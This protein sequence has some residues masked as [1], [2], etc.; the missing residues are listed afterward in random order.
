MAVNVPALLVAI[1]VGCAAIAVVA[2]PVSAFAR[3]YVSDLERAEART[4]GSSPGGTTAEP[5]TFRVQWLLT[6]TSQ[7]VLAA[8]LCGVTLMRGAAG[9]AWG[10][11][12]VALP[13][14]ALLGA[15]CGVD[16]VCHRLPNRILGPAAMWTGAATVTLVLLNVVTGTPLSEAGWAALRSVLC[17]V[18]A[19][20]IVGAM[21]LLPGS[22]MGL[23]DAKLCAVLGLWLGYFGGTYAAMGI[24]LGF[25]IGGIVAIA[26]MISR[27]AGRKTL[28]AFGPYLSRG[29][30]LCGGRAGGAP[31]GPWPPPAARRESR[32]DSVTDRGV[33]RKG[34]SP[35]RPASL[36][37]HLGAEHRRH[38]GLV[39]VSS[40]IGAWAMILQYPPASL[41]IHRAALSRSTVPPS[42][43]FPR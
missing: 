5:G 11:V 37:L 27:L 32:P 25:F 6:P 13:L 8:I 41:V 23:G 7:G 29:G 35:R 3:R 31:R 17:A 4:E 16:A 43:P 18:S 10:E 24:I 15:A 9:G 22:G 42:L 34:L 26:L 28:I 20:V 14:V 30:W 39:F 1:A 2:C 21:A 12:I 33:A 38:V 36:L 40:P 19:G